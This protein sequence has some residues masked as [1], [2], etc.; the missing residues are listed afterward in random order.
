MAINMVK[1]IIHKKTK[2]DTQ[3]LFKDFACK[4]GFYEYVVCNSI[5]Q[6]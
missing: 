3:V 4:L 2:Q 5:K 6:N 1:N